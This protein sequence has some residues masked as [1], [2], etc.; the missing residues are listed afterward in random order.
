MK[1]KKKGDAL[2]FPCFLRFALPAPLLPSFFDFLGPPL[3]LF[4][5]FLILLFLAH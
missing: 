5:F 2:R 4:A 3:L 1:N